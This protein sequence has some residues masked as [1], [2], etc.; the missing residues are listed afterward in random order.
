HFYN[1]TSY[2]FLFFSEV[3]TSSPVTTELPF[4]TSC[5]YWSEWI[6]EHHPSGAK[7]GGGKGS[8]VKGGGGNRGDSEK[9]ML[10]R[11]QREYKFCIEGY[12]SDIECREADT[13]LYYSETGD[14]KLMCSLHGGFRCRARDQSSRLCKD[15]KIRYY[16]SCKEATTTPTTPIITTRPT[17]PPI[18]VEPCTI[19]YDIVD[20]PLPLPDSS[21]KASS[22]RSE[23]SAPHNARL[24]SVVTSYSAGGWI[25]G[26]INEFQFIEVDLGRIQP[27]YGVI[28]KGRSGYPEWVKSYKVL[29]SRDGIGYA[30]VSDTNGKEKI[31]SGNYDNESPV[32][33]VFERP[34]EAR[35]VR[36]QPLT[37]HRELALR[38]GILGCAEGM[39]TLPSTTPYVPPCIEE[40]GLYNGMISDYQIKTSSNRS[41]NSDG[42][43]VRLNTP[44]TED[45]SGGWVTEFLDKDQYVQIAFFDER[46]LTGVKIQGRDMVPQWVT[47]FTVSYS[48]DGATW[49]YIMD[50][51]GN[52]AIFP[53]NYDSNSVSIVYFPQPVKAQFIRINPVAWE[54]WISM[55]LEILGCFPEEEV[56]ANITEPTEP[57]TLEGCTD[58]MGFENGELPETLITVSSTNGPGT[59]V[60]RI[61]LN[62]H[63]DGERTGGWVPALYDYKPVVL[64]DFYGERNLTGITTQGREDAN[65]WVISYTVQY[66]LDNYTWIDAYE[67]DTKDKVFSGNFDRNTPVTRWFRHMIQARFLKITILDYHTK[68]ALRMEVFGCFIPYGFETVLPEILHTTTEICVQYGPWLSLSDPASSYLGD[69]E[70]IDQIIAASGLCKNPYEIQCRSMVTQ[71]D[72]SLTGQLVRCDLEHGLLCKNADQ[73]SHQCYNYEVRL[74]CWT[75]GMETTTTELIPLE[76]C[77]EVPEYLKENC[78]VSCPYNSACDGST[79]VP[80]IDCPC[81]KDGKRFEPSNIAVTKNCERCDCII[82]GHSICKPIQCP[83]CL[84]GQISQMDEH[85]NCECVGCEEGKVLCPSNGYCIREEQWCDGIADCPDDEINCPTTMPPTTTTTVAITTKLPKTCTT[86]SPSDTD[87]CEMIANVFET[88]DG[89]TYEYEI[90]DHVL[91]K[92]LSSNS[93]SVT[94]HKTCLPENANSCI[95]YLIIEVDG[96]NFKIGPSIEDITIQ[97][98][99]VP[100]SNLWLVSQRFKD[101]FDL[102]KKGNTLIFRSKKYNFDVIWDNLHDAAIQVS[103]CLIGQIAG[104]CGLYNKEQF[105]DKTTPDGRL[106]KDTETFGDSWSVGSLERCMPPTCPFDIKKRATEVCEELR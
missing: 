37:Y 57:P 70:P 71:K 45:H 15:Y 24:S 49:S 77:P 42:R 75:C 87:T 85:C 51:T 38:L 102:K 94:V 96:L 29:Y 31:F 35:Y 72:Y 56:K 76:I 66:S 43:F 99:V 21:L 65:M 80:R 8:G 17:I 7:S 47:A 19:Y 2:I 44:Q 95:R 20:G 39:T 13:D 86:D 25:A 36:I 46:T 50:A 63:A 61:R 4:V 11:L 59:G 33:H 34:F 18:T 97:D 79:C 22:S 106:V 40:M 90:C 14:K 88:F 73:S 60:S 105:D 100:T 93:Y 62:T 54:N 68:P 89:T 32:E 9:A 74:K 101:N 58:P 1:E 5:D 53:G 23:D 98:T 48:K 83:D 10:L 28:T 30:Y 84:P 6:N 78:P 92:D 64:I 52:K 26:E 41:P 16:C 104:L 103:K 67:M 3:I 81:F 12:L 69:E 27:V 55:R 82:E 91:M